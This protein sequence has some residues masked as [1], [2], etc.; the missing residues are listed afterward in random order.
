MNIE[1]FHKMYWG[2]TGV[3]VTNYMYYY[4]IAIKRDRYYDH[5][6]HEPFDPHYQVQVFGGGPKNITGRDV[7]KVYDS[8][9]F[10]KFNM[11]KFTLGEYTFYGFGRTVESP[12]SYENQNFFKFGFYMEYHGLRTMLI[13]FEKEVYIKGDGK[14]THIGTCYKRIEGLSSFLPL[15]ENPDVKLETY[16]YKELCGTLTFQEKD[17]WHMIPSSGYPQKKGDY[18]WST[19]DV[20]NVDLEFFVFQEVKNGIWKPSIELIRMLP[21]GD[22]VIKTKRGK[23]L[24]LGIHTVQLRNNVA[25]DIGQYYDLTGVEVKA[26]KS[27]LTSFKN[28]R[29]FSKDEKGKG[30]ILAKEK[31]EKLKRLAE[32]KA[33]TYTLMQHGKVILKD[34][35]S[36]DITEFF[37]N[38][39]TSLFEQQAI[40]AGK[41][42]FEASPELDKIFFGNYGIYTYTE[43]SGEKF[44]HFDDL[45][46]INKLKGIKVP[47]RVITLFEHGEIE[48]PSYDKDCGDVCFDSGATYIGVGKDEDGVVFMFEETGDQGI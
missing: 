12:K 38:K 33:D 32:I 46:Y 18:T 7:E 6:D 40:I 19:D 17:K 30:E 28:L 37:E 42:V 20:G 11:K 36:Y 13:K 31:G 9:D 29:K 26:S 10:E 16:D 3:K 34:V 4:P 15:L 48:F 45:E 25:F 22:K 24:D 1:D 21:I 27:V 2:N 41:K 39:E 47:K 14:Y 5:R 35:R 43:M 44:A 8:I 23:L